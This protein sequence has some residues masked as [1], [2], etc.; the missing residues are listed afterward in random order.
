LKRKVYRLPSANS[1][2]NSVGCESKSWIVNPASRHWLPKRHGATWPMIVTT[3]PSGGS[4]AGRVVGGA[5]EGGTVAGGAVGAG[6]VVTGGAVRAGAAVGAG[7][8]GAE[9]AGGAVGGA[10]GGAGVVGAA[11]GVTTAAV[12]GVGAAVAGAADFGAVVAAVCA[13]SSRSNP[14]DSG[15]PDFAMTTKTRT[16]TPMNANNIQTGKPRSA[17]CHQLGGGGPF[18]DGGGVC[19]ADAGARGSGGGAPMSTGDPDSG[20][21]SSATPGVGNPLAVSGCISGY[22]GP[23]SQTEPPSVM[24]VKGNAHARGT[25]DVR[26]RNESIFRVGRG[27]GRQIG[28]TRSM[29]SITASL[30]A[31]FLSPA[32]M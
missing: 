25:A 5:V 31:S 1:H 14:S 21:W 27:L 26:G 16:M 32:T 30:K 4:V 23:V 7:I 18:R 15:S 11:V 2:T 20:V 8:A 19:N 17:R 3:G 13:V 9:V 12:E 28:T 10:V 24:A 22:C 6:A 29:K